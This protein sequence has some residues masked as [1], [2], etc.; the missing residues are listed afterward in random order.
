M[1]VNDKVKVISLEEEDNGTGI[2]VGCVGL[3]KREDSENE[4]DFP[5]EDVFY[6]KL[7]IEII[8]EPVN[9]EKDGT[10]Q[11]FRRQLEVIND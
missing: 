6:V 4:E 9:L 1:K 11:F 2:S 8:G 5:E 3:I 10:Y 7:D